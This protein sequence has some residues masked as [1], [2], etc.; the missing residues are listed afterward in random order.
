MSLEKFNFYLSQLE[1]RKAGEK[2]DGAKEIGNRFKNKK[3]NNLKPG[4]FAELCVKEIFRSKSIEL[5]KNC[6]VENTT[7]EADEHIKN[8]NMYVEVK[9]YSFYSC[10]TA[11]EKLPGFFFKLEEYNKPALIIFCGEFEL[12]TDKFSSKIWNAYHSPDKTKRFVATAAIVN[13]IRNKIINIVKLSELPDWI[14][15]N[16]GDKTWKTK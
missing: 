5:N 2:F 3:N 8:L 10:G 11:N 15:N 14:E 4:E 6:I 7:Y 9:N 13:S 1:R 16:A 12:L